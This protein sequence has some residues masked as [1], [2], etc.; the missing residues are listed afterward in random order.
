VISWERRDFKRLFPALSKE[1]EE[2][3]PRLD[4]PPEE[5]RGGG[6]PLRGFMPRP[7][8]YLSRCST[9]EE[10]LRV[11]EFLRSRGEISEVEAEKLKRQVGKRGVRSFGPLREENY[12]LKT[13]MRRRREGWSGKLTV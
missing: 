6:E 4:S 2:L 13:Y 12:Y 11:I 10:A 7:E 8:D 9:D 5:R 1:L 3:G